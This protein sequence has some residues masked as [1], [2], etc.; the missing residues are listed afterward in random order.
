[1]KFRIATPVWLT[2]YLCLG[3]CF[4]PGTGGSGRGAKPAPGAEP[5]IGCR[6]LDSAGTTYQLVGDLGTPSSPIA[7]ETSSCLVV[8]ASDVTLNLGGF[9]LYYEREDG[10]SDR[11]GPNFYAIDVLAGADNFTLTDTV[12][13]GAIDNPDASNGLQAGALRI[14]GGGTITIG[15][16]T[17]RF[18]IDQNRDGRHG[19]PVVIE[20]CGDLTIQNVDFTQ[21]NDPSK[22]HHLQGGP[23][24]IDNC[25]SATLRNVTVTTTAHDADQVGVAIGGTPVEL[26]N[27]DIVALYGSCI[28][29][30][31]ESAPASADA[32]SSCNGEP[33][34]VYDVSASGSNVTDVVAGAIVITGA[35]D[36]TFRKFHLTNSLI[37]TEKANRNVFEDFTMCK[38]RAADGTCATFAEGNIM[39]QS[40]TGNSFRRFQVW[41]GR[42]IARFNQAFQIRGANDT[43]IEDFELR[44][45]GLRAI[46]MYAPGA[47]HNFIAR[48][49]LI[50]QINCGATD[51]RC[52]IGMGIYQRRCNGYC[53]WEDVEIRSSGIGHR[54]NSPFC[55]DDGIENAVW[56][57]RVKYSAQEADF[58]IGRSD[59]IAPIC[60]FARSVNPAGPEP[61]LDSESHNAVY[62]EIDETTDRDT[63][64]SPGPGDI[65]ACIKQLQVKG[66]RVATHQP[67][68][69]SSPNRH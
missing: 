57:N 33:L 37:L 62:L 22:L 50:E 9:N 7:V 5:V 34:L 67:C 55:M 31:N 60:G 17:N 11:R 2:I 10:A 29:I 39:V 64:Q 32:A 44:S 13:N 59:H 6:Q 47:P 49:G 36:M 14:L 30:W 12:G 63:I 26:E 61:T 58:S 53:L 1:M 38:T 20:D 18:T 52:A 66:R 40:S 35:D 68:T 23:L 4:D 25:S 42:G 21:E 24:S 15:H 46:Y 48:R 43:V 19:S 45:M 28:G 69:L 41:G 56:H 8:A 65:Q 27:L 16:S 54:M 51:G 3:G